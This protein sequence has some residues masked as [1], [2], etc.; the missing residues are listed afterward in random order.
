MKSVG[1]VNEQIIEISIFIRYS[2]KQ[3]KYS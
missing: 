2:N 3:K 1:I